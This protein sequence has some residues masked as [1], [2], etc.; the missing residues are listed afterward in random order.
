[1]FRDDKVV[2][3]ELDRFNRLDSKPRKARPEAA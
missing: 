3:S 1:M 2:L